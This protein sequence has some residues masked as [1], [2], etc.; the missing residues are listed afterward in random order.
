MLHTYRM[1]TA[2]IL[3]RLCGCAG[4][5]ETLQFLYAINNVMRVYLSILNIILKLYAKFNSIKIAV[6]FSTI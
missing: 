6:L 2:K 4:F 1:R 3:T 5:S